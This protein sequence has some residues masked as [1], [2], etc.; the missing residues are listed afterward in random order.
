[1]KD[2]IAEMS[3]PFHT[4][5]TQWKQES[6]KYYSKLAPEEKLTA[7]QKF[8]SNQWQFAVTSDL[9]STNSA[10]LT[11]DKP[12]QSWLP[13]VQQI[14]KNPYDIGKLG[15]LKLY[16]DSIGK[17]QLARYVKNRMEETR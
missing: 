2:Q 8:K 4:Q 3:K 12:T 5:S 14:Q 16:F 10:E 9:W 13:L 11:A 17:T 7:D 15:S 6:E 1:M